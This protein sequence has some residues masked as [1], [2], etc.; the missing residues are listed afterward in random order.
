MYEED[1]G[2]IYMRARYYSP[3]LRRFINA[4]K[5]HGDITNALTLNRYAFCNGDPANG[6]DPTGFSKERG[7]RIYYDR[8][9]AV[10]YAYK[11]HNGWNRKYMKMDDDDF[12]LGYFLLYGKRSG[13][14][15]ANFVS[16]C[17]EAGNVKQTDEWYYYTEN[18]TPIR[19]NINSLSVS[20]SCFI[21]YTDSDGNITHRPYEYEFS[22][23]WTGANAQYKYFSDKSNGYI[24]GEVITIN[25]VDDISEAISNNNIQKGDLLYW[26]NDGETVH[27]ASM[28]ST[29]TNNDIKYTAHSDPYYDESLNEKIG[30]ETVFIV[31][32]NDYIN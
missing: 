2:L 21:W 25:S 9:A 3:E 31:R 10:K 8:D 5:V 17:L 7:G 18:N 30:S 12:R 11:Y 28:I 13:Y 22:S 23:A 4:D 20:Y 6:I 27:H 1:T 15:C 16:Q 32:M 29:V 24:N 14:D 26:S 19:R